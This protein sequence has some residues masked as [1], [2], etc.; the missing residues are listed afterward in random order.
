M[1]ESPEVHALALAWQDA[2][3]GQSI[4]GIELE[5]ARV[6]K[7]RQISPSSLLGTR[8]TGVT[9][10]GKHVCLVGADIQLLVSF[11]RSGWARW[12]PA[13]EDVGA[14]QGAAAT[15]APATGTPT[16]SAPIL[17]RI[18]FDTGTLQ[19]TDSG[20]WLSVSLTATRDAAALPSI[21][22]LG[23][24]PLTEQYARADFD[25]VV[26]GRRKQ[27]KALLQEQESF[28]GIGNAYSDEILH[29][30]RLS[31]RVRA[32]AL[33]SDEQDRLYDTVV[34]VMRN[35]AQ[36]C[37]GVPIDRQKAAKGI[38]M[39]VHGRAGAPCPVCAD[40][41]LSYRSGA[42]SAEYCPRCQTDGEPLTD[43]TT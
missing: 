28:A 9:R 2:L 37:M 41:V 7:T 1:P 21:V 31:P 39:R 38:R 22:K 14:D 24:D 3:T 29:A 26:V 10:Y 40:T 18:G 36:A 23:A 34:T 43:A 13:S 12:V 6:W 27:L 20:S 8:I 30:G 19:L 33:S 25:R 32:D 16:A 4:V 17:A 15:G 35:A 5:E 11:G 42:S